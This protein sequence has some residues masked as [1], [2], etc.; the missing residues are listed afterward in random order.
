MRPRSQSFSCSLTRAGK[1]NRCPDTVV[2]D[3]R[4]LLCQWT[5]REFPVYV[6]VYVV[7]P[8]SLAFLCLCMILSILL[9]TTTRNPSTYYVPLGSVLIEAGPR[10]FCLRQSWSQKTLPGCFITTQSGSPFPV[11]GAMASTGTKRN[12]D[13]RAKHRP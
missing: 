4:L 9:S 13:A 11:R 1:R 2:V 8:S 7:E 6:A 10:S 3:D 5:R 12:S